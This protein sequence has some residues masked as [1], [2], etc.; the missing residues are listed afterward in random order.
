MKNFL[1]SGLTCL[2]LLSGMPSLAFADCNC[3][4]KCAEKCKHGKDQNCTCEDCKEHGGCDPK[5]CAHHHKRHSH[6]TDGEETSPSESKTKPHV[7][8]NAH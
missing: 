1:L 4:Q 7:K 3:D 6:K 2:A 8:V 5:K